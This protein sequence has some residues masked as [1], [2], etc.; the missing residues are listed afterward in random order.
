VALRLG[1]D[2]ETRLHMLRPSQPDK[3]MHG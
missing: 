1:F 2:P 3:V